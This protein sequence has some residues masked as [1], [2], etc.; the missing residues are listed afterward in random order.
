MR[1]AY[2]MV[3]IAALGF[4]RGAQSVTASDLS[5]T[6]AC[7]VSNTHP[8]QGHS[9][10]NLGNTRIA[11]ALPKGA[12]FA[13]VPEGRPGWAAIQNDGWI[14]TKLGW[15]TAH[16]APSIVGRRLDQPAR[17]LRADIGPLSFAAGT[18][19]FYPSNLYFPSF[20]CW[21]ITATA[22][23]AH[24][25]AIVKVVRHTRERVTDDQQPFGSGVIAEHGTA[26]AP[27]P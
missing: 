23:G 26:H 18:G 20:G 7:R 17:R 24:L 8:V 15:W 14:R 6:G 10:F 13:A 2:V 19:S 1:V 16:G 12:T 5:S 4:A 21:R 11:V 22:D 27:V 9:S 3:V 25:T